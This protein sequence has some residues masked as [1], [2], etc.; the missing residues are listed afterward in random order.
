MAHSSF[1]TGGGQVVETWNS[2]HYVQRTIDTPE[3][4]LY[5][6]YLQLQVIHAEIYTNT[7]NKGHVQLVPGR[8]CTEYN[9]SLLP[10]STPA[11]LF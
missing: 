1:D 11:S 8:I 5:M 10:V 2:L 3:N 9:T 4:C 7:M 6:L